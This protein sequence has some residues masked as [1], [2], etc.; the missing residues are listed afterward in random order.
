[1][2]R[3][4]SAIV[5]V[6]LVP[7]GLFAEDKKEEKLDLYPL[8]KG[9]KWEYTITVNGKVIDGNSIQ[10]VTELTEPKKKG[11]K[12]TA[13]MTTT[14]TVGEKKQS[15]TIELTVD[16]TGVYSTG[17]GTIRSDT[18]MLVI[19]LPAKSGTK[20]SEK[21][22]VGGQ[23]VP[24]AGE[25]KGSEKVQVPAGEYSAYPMVTTLGGKGDSSVYTSWHADGVGPVKIQTGVGERAITMELKK[26]TSGK[27]K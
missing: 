6:A 14:V 1:M 18:P 16:E 17:D 3:P 20:W 25:M 26:F 9:N 7:S 23:E 5:L 11:D 22:K 15:S 4:W 19:K 24:Y 27:G 21:L 2:F 8:A 12:L 13:K 10:E